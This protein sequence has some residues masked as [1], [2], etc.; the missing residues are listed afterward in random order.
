MRNIPHEALDAFAEGMDEENARPENSTPTARARRALRA[1]PFENVGGPNLVTARGEPAALFGTRRA[2]VITRHVTAK[3]ATPEAA[4]S[5]VSAVMDAVRH[6]TDLRALY[7]WLDCFDGDVP[8]RVFGVPLDANVLHS[9][10]EAFPALP[11]AGTYAVA[12]VGAVL[13]DGT[14]TEGL[15]LAIEHDGTTV[16]VIGYSDAK[17]C[18]AAWPIPAGVRE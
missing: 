15:V 17:D 12:T 6:S 8:V 14:R 13:P 1:G 9:V 11:D 2:L 3:K 7:R 16:G 18:V 4:Q 5:I 10:F